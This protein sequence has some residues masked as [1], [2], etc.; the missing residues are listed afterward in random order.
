MTKATVD[1]VTTPV[2]EVDAPGEAREVR[3][4]NDPGF[5]EAPTIAMLRGA[6]S[7]I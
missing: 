6:Q 2:D 5:G 4:S 7:L 3:A 1:L